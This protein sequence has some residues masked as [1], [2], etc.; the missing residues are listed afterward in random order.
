MS[1]AELE[2]RAEV[3]KLERLLERD[4]PYLATAEVDD[5][6]ALREQLIDRLYDGDR[7]SLGRVASA[8]GMLPV[9]VL[10]TIAEKAIHP[11]LCARIVGLISVDRAVAVGSKLPPP[12]LAQI[13]V[14]MDPRRAVTVIRALPTG[15]VAET[16]ALLAEREEFAVM[17][18][19]VGVLSDEAMTACFDRLTE[20]QMLHVGY[21]LDDRAS[22]SRVGA[23]LEQ[24]R[25]GTM[26]R[27]ADDEDLWDEA[28]LLLAHFDD[29]LLAKL[30]DL[31]SPEVA[32]RARERAALH[33][34]S[35]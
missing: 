31:A 15:L 6:V 32:E 28:L 7:A 23:L 25:I 8:S 13:A 17:G 27:L 21:L 26:I 35:L 5:L 24:E 19:F 34:L 14:E 33:G 1:L 20:R 3:L 30:D 18:R 12:F 9:G 4:L 2:A 10:A 22:L 16:A 11:V 29:D